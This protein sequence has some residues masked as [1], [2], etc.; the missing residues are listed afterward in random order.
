MI[1]GSWA[2]VLVNPQFVST[3]FFVMSIFFHRNWKSLRM[4]TNASWKQIEI[5]LLT[6]QVLMLSTETL[7]VTL[8]CNQILLLDISVIAVIWSF[9]FDKH[10]NK[11]PEDICNHVFV[12]VFQ[13]CT[14][15]APGMA[16]CAG[17]T[18]KQEP[19]PPK[20][21]LIIFLTSTQQVSS[22]PQEIFYWL[23]LKSLDYNISLLYGLIKV[24][25]HS[26][27]YV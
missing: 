11:S 7:C 20:T 15:V 13:V 1:V 16:C 2:T 5:H 14:A 19:S 21:A 17:T 10:M 23:Y 8:V 24:Y 22:E 3:M 26:C 9:M 6:N 18:L 27:R 4:N 12:L 25:G